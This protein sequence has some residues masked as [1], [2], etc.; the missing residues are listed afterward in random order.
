MKQD[1]KQGISWFRKQWTDK[2]FRIC[3]II[4]LT[5]SIGLAAEFFLFAYSI[6]K[7]SRYLVLAAALFFIAWIDWQSRRIPNRILK[8]LLTV[9]GILL[10][11]EWLTYP[12]LGLAV[13]LSALLGAAIGGGMFLIAHFISKGGVGMGDVKLFIVIGSYMGSGSI[14]TAVFLS[15][16]ASAFYSIAMLLLK[17]IKLKEEIPFA[18]FIFVGTVLTMALGM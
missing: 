12:K 1:M 17:K 15:V 11:A 7:I 4:A 18:P 10:A 3:L 9:R 14:M 2:K 13:L 16:M 8:M 6:W 5:V